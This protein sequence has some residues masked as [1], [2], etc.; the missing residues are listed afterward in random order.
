MSRTTLHRLSTLT[1]GTV[2]LGMPYGYAVKTR[3]PEPAQAMR[4]LDAAWDAGV[5][6]FDTAHAY[7]NAEA[8]LGRW[9]QKPA[10]VERTPFIVSKFPALKG[11]NPPASLRAFAVQSRQTLGRQRVDAY[12]AHNADDIL[13]PGVA[14]TLRSLC[15]EGVIGSFGVSVYETDELER[16]L[17]VDGLSVVQVPASL[18]DQRFRQSGLLQQCAERGIAVF[19]RS[20]FLQ[21]VLFLAGRRLP[22]QLKP[23]GDRVAALRHLAEDSGCSLAGLALAAVMAMP[24]VDSVVLGVANQAQLTGNIEAL[25][26]KPGPDTIEQ[27]M[28]IGAG[29]PA[30]VIDPR[31]WQ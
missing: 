8:T 20:V 10:A 27:A 29:L 16:A 4:L 21:G 28:E 15:G 9:L 14:D 7:G 5:T 17:E 6:C 24:G 12:L 31:Q 26:Q 18:L 25:A 30:S 3:P 22:E 13:L 11:G 19:A 1:L 23:A 2:Q